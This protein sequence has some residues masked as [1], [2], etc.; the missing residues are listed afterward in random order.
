MAKEGNCMA[1][2][3][4]PWCWRRDGGGHVL[5]TEAGG[6]LVVLG[7]LG[8]DADAPRV[9]AAR[10]DGPAR[11]V[12]LTPEHPDARLIRAA[13]LLL[14]ACQEALAFFAELELELFDGRDDLPEQVRA[15]VALATVPPAPCA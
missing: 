13:P 2:T 3:Q 1:H 11:L 6:A 8:G 9:L 10:L 14:A 5:T 7:T 15:A 4:G 12:P